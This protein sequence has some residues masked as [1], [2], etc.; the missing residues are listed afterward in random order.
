MIENEFT[1]SERQLK[2][3]AYFGKGLGALYFLAA[4]FTIFLLATGQ[5][6]PAIVF[7]AIT[8]P[9]GTLSYYGSE[10]IQS[11]KTALE[12]VDNE[13]TNPKV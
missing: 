1:L 9:L 4:V 2:I 10:V 11:I 12:E 7:I 13:N 5:I 3:I 8:A 6:I